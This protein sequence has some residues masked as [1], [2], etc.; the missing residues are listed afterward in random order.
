MNCPETNKQIVD[1]GELEG[2]GQNSKSPGNFMN[3]RENRYIV[4]YPPPP[5]LPN[6]WGGV[7]SQHWRDGWE[8]GTDGRE[9]GM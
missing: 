2:G 6:W 7:R 1:P 3:C 5:S 4:V 8:G 9:G